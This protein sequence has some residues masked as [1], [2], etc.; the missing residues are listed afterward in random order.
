MDKENVI[1]VYRSLY[2]D[3]FFRHEKTKMLLQAMIALALED[4]NQANFNEPVLR[5]NNLT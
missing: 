5:M 3:Q 2:L 1:F 4:I